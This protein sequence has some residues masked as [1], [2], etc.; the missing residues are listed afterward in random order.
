MKFLCNRMTSYFSEYS[1]AHTPL[2][3]W[4]INSE[5]SEAQR[6]F[7]E[8]LFTEHG[9]F[10]THCVCVIIQVRA[11]EQRFHLAIFD[12]KKMKFGNNTS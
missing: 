11:T 4:L 5:K 8:I 6:G 3:D 7:H 9:A 10:S 2:V 12:T 1:R